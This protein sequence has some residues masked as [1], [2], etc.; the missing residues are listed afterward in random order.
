VNHKELE[1]IAQRPERPLGVSLLS[2][3][4]GVT[5][6]FI[7]ALRFGISIARNVGQDDISILAMCLGI[8]LPVA[9]IT[10]AIGTFRGNDRSRV[11]LIILLTLYFSLTTFQSVTLIVTGRLTLEEQFWSYAG[12]LSAI[13]TLTI[14]LWYFLRPSTIAYFRKPI[15]AQE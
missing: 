3:W 10:A 15:S 6:G 12:I 13:L 8:G 5:I 9:I 11:A 14:N 7:P 1:D 2:I 4:N